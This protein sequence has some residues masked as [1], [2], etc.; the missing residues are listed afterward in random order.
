MRDMTIKFKFILTL[1]ILSIACIIG[2]A[3]AANMCIVDGTTNDYHPMMCDTSGYLKTTLGTAL[4]STSDSVACLGNV[5]HDAVDSGNPLK[6]GMKSVTLKATLTPVTSGDRVDWVASRQGVPFVYSGHPNT[7]RVG[8][9]R[10]TTV[11]TN[12]VIASATSTQRL[13]ITQ[14]SVTVSN[15]VSVSPSILIGL[16]TAT[17]PVSGAGILFDH[18]TMPAGTTITIGGGDILA[19]GELDEDLRITSDVPTGGSIVVLVTYAVMTDN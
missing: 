5:A 2:N 19:I 6:I 17:T 11:L 12:A 3:K 14:I 4:T 1:I 10:L 9:G 13:V 7:I 8:S 18:P 15:T 16:A